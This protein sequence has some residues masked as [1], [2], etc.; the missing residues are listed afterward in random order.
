MAGLGFVLL[1]G[2][3][4]Q[5]AV[6]MD[7]PPPAPDPRYGFAAR[8]DSMAFRV[9]SREWTQTSAGDVELWWNN[10]CPDGTT[11]YWGALR[12]A[13]A[14]A[15]FSCDSWQYYKWGSVPAGTHHLEFRKAHDGRSIHGSGAMRAGMPVVVHPEP[16]P[17]RSPTAN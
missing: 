12:P 7:T 2:P 14:T 15:R 5:A 4:E 16:A 17:T 3:G 10:S 1:R 13:G 11:T 8:I 6:A 9:L